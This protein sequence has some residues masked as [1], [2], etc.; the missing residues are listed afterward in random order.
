LKRL[1]IVMVLLSWTLWTW[2]CID[3]PDTSQLLPVGTPFVVR[4][5]MTVVERQGPCLVWIGENGVQYHLFQSPLLANEAFDRINTP[6]VISRLVV[7][8]RS[9]LVFGC[10][11]G[12]VVEVRDVLE[13]A[14]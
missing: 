12:T 4:G 1:L 5:T 9:D 3:L 13:I 6:G 7:A 10:Q 2:G 8:T 14:G 11:I